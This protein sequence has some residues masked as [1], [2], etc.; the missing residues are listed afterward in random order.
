ML[1]E[2]NL[3]LSLQFEVFSS[4]GF[5]FFDRLEN[6]AFSL[7]TDFKREISGS[8]CT[9]VKCRIP[10]SFNLILPFCIP[11]RQLFA[12]VCRNSIGQWKV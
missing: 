3:V 4:F 11:G 6:K 2:F 9:L 5:F 10:A 12:S 7:V 8:G 1:N